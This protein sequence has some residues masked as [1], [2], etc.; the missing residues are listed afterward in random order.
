MAGAL[1]CRS[2]GDGKFVK[3]RRTPQSGARH[4]MSVVEEAET[5]EPERP[6]GILKSHWA[7]LRV[8][9]RNAELDKVILKIF[10]VHGYFS[11]L[12]TSWP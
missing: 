10:A 7:A 1:L 4:L 11:I 3:R 12:L 6:L 8:A 2:A 5:M 9:A